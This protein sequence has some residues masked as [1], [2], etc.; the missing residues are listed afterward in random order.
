M[1]PQSEMSS[2]DMEVARQRAEISRLRAALRQIADIED[3][4][5]GSDWC[6][7]EKA[8]EIANTALRNSVGECGRHQEEGQA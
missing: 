1:R 4:E 7:I 8:R 6:E 2:L 5:Y 3:E